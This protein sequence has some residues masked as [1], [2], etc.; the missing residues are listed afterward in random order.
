[1]LLCL[2]SACKFLV[3]YV[4]VLWAVVRL[5]NWFSWDVLLVFWDCTFYTFLGSLVAVFS[6]I[7]SLL[8]GSFLDNF[9]AVCWAYC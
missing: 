2:L 1:M 7:L 5:L 6:A 9:G 4:T 8:S 3:C